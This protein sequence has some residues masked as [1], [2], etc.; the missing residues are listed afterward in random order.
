MHR[1]L[2]ERLACME[3]EVALSVLVERLP[4]LR[5]VDVAERQ[6]G[7]VTHLPSVICEY[8]A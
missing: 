2:G 3:L 1:C 5:V 4:G 8:D 6:F 7:M